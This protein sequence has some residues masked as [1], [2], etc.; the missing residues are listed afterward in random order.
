MVRAPSP[1]GSTTPP[2]QPPPAFLP[3]LAAPRRHSVP[4]QAPEPLDPLAVDLPPLDSSSA[5][6][7]RYPHRGCRAASS[8]IASPAAAR[9][10]PASAHSAASSGADPPPARP[11]LRHLMPPHQI[12]DSVTPARRA[13]HFPF[14]KSFSIEMSNACSATI[15]LQPAVLLLQRL[16]PL[17]LVLLQ[18]PVLDPP[19]IERLLADPEPLARRGI[20]R[21]CA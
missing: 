8:F 15:R 14:C 20:V 9:T 3:L 2:A 17:R 13:H 4:F 21:P 18:R 16:Q 19:P 5:Q 11:T 7:V 6:T 1:A 10:R 12:S